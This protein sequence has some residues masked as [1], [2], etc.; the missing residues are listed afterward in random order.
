MRVSD[1]FYQNW[2]VRRTF[3]APFFSFMAIILAA[4]GGLS[5][6]PDIIR[7]FPPPTEA[8]IIL[9]QVPPNLALGEQIYRANCTACHG[10]SG[11]GDGETALDT[12]AMNLP[13]FQLAEAIDGQ[14]PEDY[15]EIITNGRLDKFMPPWV[16]SLTDEERWAVAMYVYTLHQTD[17]QLAIGEEIYVA[18]CAECHGD[19]G[20]GDGERAITESRD[21]GDLT[22]LQSMS[23]LSDNHIFV[24]VNEGAGSEMPA[25][26]DDLTQDEQQA[27][28]AYAR[29]LSL[30]TGPL[31]QPVSTPFPEDTVLGRVSGHVSNG[32]AG[33]TIPQ[34]MT[35]LFVQLDENDEVLWSDETTSDEA[36]AYAFENVPIVIGTRYGV[37]TTYQ[38]RTFV[39][40]QFIENT[41]QTDITTNIAIYETTQD[42]SVL[43]ITQILEQI[44]PEANRLVVDYEIH[45]ANSSDRA[46]STDLE[47]SEGRF[48]SV[49]IN[50]P[51]S[52]VISGIVGEGSFQFNNE[53]ARLTDTRPVLPGADHII[54]LQYLLSYNNEAIM[55][56]PLNYASDG[57]VIIVINNDSF[58][59]ISDDLVRIEPEAVE[60]VDSPTYGGILRRPAGDSL[61]YE[62][63]GVAPPIGTSAD[64][65]IV[66]SN[67]FLPVIIGII[68]VIAV[69]LTGL[70]FLSRRSPSV[71][72]PMSSLVD[73]LTRQ[74]ETLESQH[75]A[76]QINHDVY[77]RRKQE[78]QARLSEIDA[79][80]P[81]GVM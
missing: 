70:I 2:F 75:N 42:P 20:R 29:R 26:G 37:S 67:N 24:N 1:T 33:G 9:P 38:G 16:E 41:D 14:T 77:Q 56:Y 79:S 36:G 11:A 17:D 3:Y 54:R 58:E 69:I 63:R 46:F 7:T 73:G 32:T 47:L 15:Y 19:E 43:T 71:E 80:D 6:E 64:N 66:T 59:I 78:L 60:S 61:I 8:P 62:I 5:G 55:D 22:D 52:A 40:G 49:E 50:L 81:S 35:V 48:A 30:D 45:F 44:T 74:L 12:P 13:N 57:P 10:E 25:F 65:T 21:A 76:G 53:A 28:V 23:S 18:N 34:E 4:C 51:V 39:A 68:V 72:S 27:V 31:K